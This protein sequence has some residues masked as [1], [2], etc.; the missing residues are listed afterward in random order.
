MKKLKFFVLVVIVCLSVAVG[1]LLTTNDASASAITVSEIEQSIVNVNSVDNISKELFG[2]IEIK[3]SEYLYN[4]D[5][6]L[7]TLAVAEGDM[8]N[9]RRVPLASRLLPPFTLRALVA[10]DSA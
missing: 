4:F 9:A 6:S 8:S 2:D 5:G 1:I 3:S 7:I 10:A